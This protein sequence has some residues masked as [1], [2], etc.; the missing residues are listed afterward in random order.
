MEGSSTTPLVGGAS[1]DQAKRAQA[2]VAAVQRDLNVHLRRLDSPSLLAVDGE[3]DDETQLAF[4]R[5]CRI[6]GIEPER[7]VRT[8]RLI[9]AGAVERTDAELERAAKDGAAFA[10]EL[11]AQFMGTNGHR[12]RPRTVVGGS[13]L[14]EPARSRAYVAALQRD[15]NRHLIELGS[16]TVLAVDG[17]LASTP[18]GRSR[19]CARCSG[20]SRSRP[21]AASA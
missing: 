9:G 18:S 5:V 10:R 6:L 8:F 1:L 4:E 13:S 21:C 20:S 14:P 16:P 15:L 19:A 11:R 3:W 7:T 12:P 2:Y 17:H